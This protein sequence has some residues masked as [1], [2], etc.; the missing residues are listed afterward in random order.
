MG[1][2]YIKASNGKTYP[3][4]SSLSD[5]E[6]IDY[7][8]KQIKGPESKENPVKANE[9]I[10]NL[11]KKDV[12][13]IN[14]GKKPDSKSIKGQQKNGFEYSGDTKGHQAL[15]KFHDVFRNLGAGAGKSFQNAR[16]FV[17]SG[18]KYDNPK[19]QQAQKNERRPDYEKILG[20]DDRNRNEAIQ[21]VPEIAASLSVPG[22]RLGRVAGNVGGRV[23]GPALRTGLNAVGE[24]GLQAALGAAFNPDA[25]E[26]SAKEQGSYGAGA[27]VLSDMVMANNPLGRILKRVLPGALGAY[28]GYNIRGED[29]PTWQKVAGGTVG[30]VAGHGLGNLGR[31][32]FGG[33]GE[34]FAQPQAQRIMENMT[35]EDLARLQAAEAAGQRTGV[36]SQSVGQKTQNPIHLADEARMGSNEQNIQTIHQNQQQQVQELTSAKEATARMQKP[37]D[38][39]ITHQYSIAHQSATPQQVEGVV[40]QHLS[41]NPVYQKARIETFSNASQNSR[42]RGAPEYSMARQDQI[43]QNLDTEIRNMQDALEKGGHNAPSQSDIQEVVR[44]RDELVRDLDSVSQGGEY[45]KARRMYENK[46]FA[47]QVHNDSLEQFRNKLANRE[48]FQE[49]RNSARGNPLLQQRYDDL[50][51]IFGNMRTLNPQDMAAALQR[52][53]LSSSISNP[54][55]TAS[56]LVRRFIDGDY[57]RAALALSLNPRAL[58]EMHRLAQVSDPARRAAGLVRL[59]GKYS[60]HTSANDL[61]KGYKFKKEDY[62]KMEGEK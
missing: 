25:R 34:H 28:G 20:V 7:V 13:K 43:K 27:S 37:E 57:E 32:A 47:D 46:V 12:D 40:G 23:V 62:K 11:V 52:T 59:A 3:V 38:R 42:L 53:S 19:L 14:A 24:G 5:E 30:A 15:N 54:M 21:K 45:A 48:Q 41:D 6:A 1:I 31:R 61:N 16:D 4:D 33:R 56:A 17:Q 39:A 51:T 9:R 18:I 35:P 44:I 36:T 49:L 55:R 10:E 60:G 26:E 22:L 2:Q 8:I 29:I 50:R 58:P